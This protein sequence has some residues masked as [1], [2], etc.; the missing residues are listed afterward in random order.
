MTDVRWLLMRVVV[1]AVVAA[2][3]ASYQ[4]AEAAAVYLVVLGVL[5][6]AGWI[7]D[8]RRMAR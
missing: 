6:L 3:L 1:A 8:V 5:L 2:W 4:P 7:R